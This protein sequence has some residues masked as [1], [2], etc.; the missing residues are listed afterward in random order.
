MTKRMA[1]STPRLGEKAATNAPTMKANAVASNQLS[2]HLYGV[3]A[4][5]RLTETADGDG[6][7]RR[8]S[9]PPL[10][11]GRCLPLLGGSSVN[12]H[13]FSSVTFAQLQVVALK[14][15]G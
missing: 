14:T 5:E 12:R 7:G 3:Q 9:R 4:I 8:P 15:A 1:I 2:C 10:G 11:A 13:R 6:L